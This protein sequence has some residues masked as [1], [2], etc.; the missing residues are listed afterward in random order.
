MKVSGGKADSQT[1]VEKPSVERS[2]ESHD[3]KADGKQLWSYNSVEGW[4]CLML[5]L[6]YLELNFV[7]M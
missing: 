4:V 5:R 3:T 7:L 2:V 6:T 1:S